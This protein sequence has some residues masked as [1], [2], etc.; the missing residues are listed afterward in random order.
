ML[1]VKI[2]TNGDVV[3]GVYQLKPRHHPISSFFSTMTLLHLSLRLSAW[4][5]HLA[6]RRRTLGTGQVRTYITARSPSN[7]P[8]IK[9]DRT[10]ASVADRDIACW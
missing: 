2:F 3:T 10:W 4:Y 5:R 7:I 6:S 8:E 9:V 1:K